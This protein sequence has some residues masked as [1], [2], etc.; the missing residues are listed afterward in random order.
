MVE[1][2]IYGGGDSDVITC[3]GTVKLCIF[4]DDN[5]T[6]THGARDT[7]VVKSGG[8]VN[9]SIYGE[10]GDDTITNEGAVD[11]MIYGGEGNDEI[12]NYGTV[13]QDIHGDDLDAATPDGNDT[14]TVGGQ[15]QVAGNVLGEG[16]DDEIINNGTVTE[17]IRGEAGSDS[18][19]NYGTVLQNISGGEG[20]DHVHFLG[21]EASTLEGGEDS[22][23]GDEDT[24][25]LT[26]RCTDVDV[27]GESG[28]FKLDD[29]LVSWIE[30]EYYDDEVSVNHAP[31]AY[32]FGATGDEDEYIVVD[33][34]G[35]F[36][37]PDDSPENDPYCITIVLGLR[38]W[39]A[40]SR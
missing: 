13:D 24:L 9:S 8:M 7:I 22:G 28:S 32:S 11:N 10:G 37:D 15:G 1:G 19:Y 12:T 2:N 33:F 31:V 34:T 26:D 29:K 40:V 4:G 27:N 25:Y 17:N 3:Y 23:G 21:G 38:E 35:Q 5:D 20:N 16:G 39:D 14:I 18:I 36:D 30:F 6:A